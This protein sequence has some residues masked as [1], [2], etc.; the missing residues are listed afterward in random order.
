MVGKISKIRETAVT[1]ARD[2]SLT[3]NE[4]TLA[5]AI[6]TAAETGA[7]VIS[8]SL[9]TTNNISCATE[10]DHELCVA[11]AL[12][13]E[14]DVVVVAATGNSFSNPTVHF[15]ASDPNV[16][17]VGALDINSEVPEWSR[18]EPQQDLAAPGVRVLTT[19]YTN[20]NWEPHEAFV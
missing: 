17:S 4:T 14:M 6:T 5:A 9:V 10:P 20:R 1:P 15:L 2:G 12:A 3:I 8:L 11:L 16:I 18:Y 19:W 13:Q 7:Q